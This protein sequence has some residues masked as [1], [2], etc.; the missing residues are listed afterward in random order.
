ME[1]LSQ[2]VRVLADRLPDMIDRATTTYE[3]LAARE[4][5]E[6]VKSVAAHQAA[7][8]SALAHLEALLNFAHRLDEPGAGASP[9]NDPDML[10]QLDGQAAAAVAMLPEEQED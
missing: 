1:R 5:A 6:D 9:Q 10:D 7:L 8:R 4:M 3:R 2:Q